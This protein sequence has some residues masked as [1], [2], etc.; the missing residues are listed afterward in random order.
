[1]PELRKDPVMG[2]WVIVST[3]RGERPSAFDHAPM[4]RIQGFCPFC[5]GREGKTPPEVHA[6]RE[7]DTTPD[8]PGWRVRVVSNKYPALQ[9]EGEIER[10]AEGIFDKM[11]GVGAHEVVIE[12]PEHDLEMSRLSHRQIARVI[13]AYRVR[14]VDLAN[15]KRF[16]YIQIFKNHDEAAGA[17]LEHPHSQIIATPIVPRRVVD[18]LAGTAQHF[19]LKERCIYC[20]VI[21]QEAASGERTVLETDQY[22]ALAP[23]ASRFPFETWILPKQHRVRFEEGD[24]ED[25]WALADILKQTLAR[26]NA[27]LYSPPYNFV[28]HTAPI[29]EETDPL[30]YHWHIEIMPRLTKVA[31]FEWGTGFYINPTPPEDAARFLREAADPPERDTA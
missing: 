20:D 31:G 27:V 6:D 12:C 19:D 30:H 2:R 7:P 16:R 14:A 10:K 22:V 3:E 8:S 11:T 13:H 1:M 25:T 28:I 18:E 15:D 26:I 23:F 9:I 29:N 21:D 5:P 24:D 17:T 4:K